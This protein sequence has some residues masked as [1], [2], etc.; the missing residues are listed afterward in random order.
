M[1]AQVVAVEPDVRSAAALAAL[2]DGHDQISIEVVATIGAAVDA[3]ERCVPDLIMTTPLLRAAEE[4]DLIARLKRIPDA[5]HVPVVHIPA[6]VTPASAASEP[7]SGRFGIFRRRTSAAHACDVAALQAQMLEYIRDARRSQTTSGLQARIA[8]PPGMVPETTALVPARGIALASAEALRS[9]RERRRA[10]RRR[11]EDMPWLWTVKL[12]WGS[13]VRVLDMSST[14][15]LIETAAQLDAGGTV[16]LKMIGEEENLVM[17]AHTIRAEPA[18]MESG[19]IYRV[20]LEFAEELDTFGRHPLSASAALRPRTLTSLLGRVMADA[21][22]GSEPA[23][24]RAQFV[25]ELL[26]LMPARSIRFRSAL[27][28]SSG[29]DVV[30][31]A[32]PNATGPATVMEVAFEDGYTPSVME[33]RFLQ[34]AAAAAGVVAAFSPVLPDDTPHRPENP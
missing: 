2:F 34:A 26:E 14:G 24:V 5:R 20:G 18:W 4:A 32:V 9:G 23:N 31:F 28:P 22:R 19:V 27:A 11:R 12:P 17:P 7:A 13:D 6:G 1:T 10:R 15:M 8:D 16:E 25:H 3:I 30:H 33:F 29:E 21:E